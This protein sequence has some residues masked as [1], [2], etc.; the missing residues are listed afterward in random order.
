[1]HMRP[2]LHLIT[3]HRSRRHRAARVANPCRLRNATETLVP[4]P[5]APQVQEPRV[6][7]AP[8]PPEPQVD[9]GVQLQPLRDDL[10]GPDIALRRV[11]ESGGPIDH[12]SYA[13]Q[14]GY[15]FEA[16]VSTTVECPH[17]STSQA[18]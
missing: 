7:Q 2:N 16:D 17:C 10:R 8:Q 18:W 4:A 14:C 6:P 13:C 5:R 1:M 12:A 11:R 3:E 9:R 15:V